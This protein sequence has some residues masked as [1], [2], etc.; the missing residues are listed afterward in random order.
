MK[1]LYEVIKL[2]RTCENHHYPK[3]LDLLACSIPKNYS[4]N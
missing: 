1:P 4:W 2:L 3:G